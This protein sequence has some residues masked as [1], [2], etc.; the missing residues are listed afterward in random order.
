VGPSGEV[1]F[2]QQENNYA[3]FYV[4]GKL[5]LFME[6]D[7]TL[8]TD[9]TVDYE[10]LVTA[11]DDIPNKKYVDDAITAGGATTLDGLTDVTIGS[12]IVDNDVLTYNSGSGLWEPATPAVVITDHTALSNIGT[13]THAQIDTHIA[14]GSPIHYLQ[15]EISITE[16]QISDLQSYLLDI[17][18][19]SINDL[20]DVDVVGSPTL[21][22]GMVLTYNGV[23]WN[24]E[25]SA[26][27]ILET[28]DDVREPTGFLNRTDSEI[29]FSDTG[30][31]ATRL[32]TI[33]VLAPAT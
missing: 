12:P 29:S 9:P 20:S 17:T 25:V 24:H 3:A 4:N 13:N 2:N 28:F 23:R 8:S 33:D 5:A 15:S 1:I 7:H 19:Q 14:T 18:S 16:S 22:D 27:S 31:P 26:P 32:F 11:D 6:A 30:S 21:V 10:T